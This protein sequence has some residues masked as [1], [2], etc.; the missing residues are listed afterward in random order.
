[1]SEKK[2]ELIEFKAKIFNILT[3]SQY[4]LKRASKMDIDDF[5]DLLN[6]FNNNDI[7]FK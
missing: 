5:L 2:K 6:I 7:H 1:M 3:D 4:T